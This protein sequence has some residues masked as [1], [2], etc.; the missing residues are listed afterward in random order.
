MKS[1]TT[2]M[3]KIRNPDWQ[4]DW[5]QNETFWQRVKRTW[6]ILLSWFGVK[7]P[8][9]KLRQIHQLGVEGREE[10]AMRLFHEIGG[11]VEKSSEP[12]PPWS[13]LGDIWSEEDGEIWNVEACHHGGKSIY[14]GNIFEDPVIRGKENPYFDPSRKQKAV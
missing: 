12:L 9:E 6:W 1:S 8:M 7:P 5:I 4:R 13:E 3:E 10:E 14:V 11:T 2:E